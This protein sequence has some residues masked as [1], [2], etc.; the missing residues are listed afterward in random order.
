MVSGWKAGMMNCKTPFSTGKCCFLTV[1]SVQHIPSWLLQ[2]AD[3]KQHIY[4]TTQPSYCDS[5]SSG[6][7]ALIA[8]ANVTR[9]L[10][11]TLHTSDNLL[12]HV[13][14]GFSLFAC[15]NGCQTCCK[16]WLSQS[17]MAAANVQMLGRRSSTFQQ[18]QSHWQWLR[19][20]HP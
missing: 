2:K 7:E 16:C 8:V 1:N 19:S 13:L 15:C 6:Q 3:C 10:Q 9:L 11:A 18:W 5:I 17:C 4:I 20:H 12:L 14:S